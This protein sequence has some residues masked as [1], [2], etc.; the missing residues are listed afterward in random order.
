MIMFTKM[1]KAKRRLLLFIGFVFVHVC[2]FAQDNAKV[3]V[4]ILNGPSCI[5]IVQMMDTDS[6]NYSFE[7]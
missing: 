1:M 3:S 7:K 6:E 5:P 2:I 4:G